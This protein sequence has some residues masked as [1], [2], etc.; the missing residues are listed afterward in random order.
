MLPFFQAGFKRAKEKGTVCKAGQREPVYFK[1][2][3]RSV[4]YERVE[5]NISKHIEK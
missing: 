4:D 2:R 1:G 5:V 3:T